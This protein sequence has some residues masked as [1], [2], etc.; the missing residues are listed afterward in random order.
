MN[1]FDL[2]VMSNDAEL[3]VGRAETRSHARAVRQTALHQQSEGHQNRN[4]VFLDDIAAVLILGLGAGASHD[5]DGE[6]KAENTKMRHNNRD[7]IFV[8]HLSR[9]YVSPLHTHYLYVSP[10]QTYFHH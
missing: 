3:I 4:I 1:P 10:L 8:A 9:R 6:K 7:S 5:Q 2:R